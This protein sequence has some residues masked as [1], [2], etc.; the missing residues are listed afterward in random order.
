[1]K[2]DIMTGGKN[3]KTICIL[4]IALLTLSGIIGCASNTKSEAE[5]KEEIKK[6]LAAEMAKEQAVQ[7]EQADKDQ[8]PSKEQLAQQQNPQ[9]EQPSKASQSPEQNTSKANQQNT[10]NTP[11]LLAEY[12]ANKEYQY[13][14]NGDGRTETFKIDTDNM[15]YYIGLLT[16]RNTD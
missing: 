12:Q 5:L 3:E 15:N 7:N 16:A 4:I 1:M 13:D 2:I 8:A 11:S 6:E 14:I 10:R 9:K